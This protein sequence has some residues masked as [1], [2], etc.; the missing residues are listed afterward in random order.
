MGDGAEVFDWKGNPAGYEGYLVYCWAF[1]HS[2]LR[3][4]IELSE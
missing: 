4:E 1:I 2:M 3:T